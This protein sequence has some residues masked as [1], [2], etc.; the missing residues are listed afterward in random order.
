[1]VVEG[2]GGD[3]TAVAKT[4]R[5]GWWPA[6]IR[7]AAST[8]AVPAETVTRVARGRA[9]WARA[10]P[11]A[12][13]LPPYMMRPTLSDTVVHAH[14]LSGHEPVKNTVRLDQVT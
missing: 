8:A 10:E 6:E 5:A 13:P 1:V 11:R 14:P 12:F 9:P 4:P 3:V 2:P 7:A